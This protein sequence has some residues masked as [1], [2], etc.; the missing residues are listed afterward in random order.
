MNFKLVSEDKR[1][2]I[3]ADTELLKGKEVSIIEL[4]KGKAIGGCIHKLDENF[5]ILSG[6]V[7]VGIG[8][9][10]TIY[11]EGYTGTFFSKE[12]HMFYALKDSIIIEYG[13]TLEEKGNKKDARMLKEVNEYNG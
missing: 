4:K 6:R 8:M 13:L 1:R 10:R 12:P 5:F 11:E 7:L 9:E 2:K 3:Y